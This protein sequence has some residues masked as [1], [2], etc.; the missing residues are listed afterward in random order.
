MSQLKL[1]II[2]YTLCILYYKRVDC[3]IVLFVGFGVKNQL[4]SDVMTLES[5]YS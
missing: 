5:G 4:F 1:C 3:N 2:C